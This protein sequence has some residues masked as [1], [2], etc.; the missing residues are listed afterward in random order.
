MKKIRSIAAALSSLAAVAALTVSSGAYV[1]VVD[2]PTEFL[3]T[4]KET[5]AIILPEKHNGIAQ[6]LTR[7]EYVIALEGDLAEYDKERINGY[8]DNEAAKPF[9]D[10]EGYI[11]IGANVRVNG[12]EDNWYSFSYKTLTS[13][14]SAATV[15]IKA[16]GDN[17][18]MF[19]C[20][21]TAVEILPTNRDLQLAFKDWGNRSDYYK[22][23][24]KEFNAYGADGSAVI[25]ADANGNLEFIEPADTEA[26]A[27]EVTTEEV[28]AEETT[29]EEIT[30]EETTTEEVTTEETTAAAP[31]TTT[32]EI[33]TEATSAITTTTA[34][35]VTTA[36]TETTSAFTTTAKSG[37]VQAAG[38]NQESD[39]S[40]IIIIGIIAGV[41]IIGA[42]VGIIIFMNNKKKRNHWKEGL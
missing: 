4:D 19:S 24:V 35:A 9:A 15:D 27:E 1:T 37:T 40:A 39:N 16:L 11:G 13:S 29:T 32:Q 30:A 6:D 2:S 12:K 41:V 3:N 7:M 10:F 22:L 21:L 42:V 14:G 8:Y 38:T 34:A 20:D 28:T 18:Y 23:T 31:E 36:P 25:H 26:P 5:W 17:T 33:T